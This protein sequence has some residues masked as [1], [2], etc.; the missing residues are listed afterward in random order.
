MSGSLG[1]YLHNAGQVITGLLGANVPASVVWEAV[2]PVYDP[3]SNSLWQFLEGVLAVT[4]QAITTALVAE[5]LNPIMDEY[6]MMSIYLL[7]APYF[8]P[9]A[10]AKLRRWS[11]AIRDEIN[12]YVRPPKIRIQVPMASDPTDLPLRPDDTNPGLQPLPPPAV[13]SVPW[14]GGGGG[15]IYIDPNSGVIP[16][17]DPM[18]PPAN[19]DDCPWQRGPDGVCTAPTVEISIDD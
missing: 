9:N 10:L 4:G 6:T 18:N 15:D 5:T 16:N 12:L 13:D 8:M 17:F 14:G 19:L 1:W 7:Y 11:R 3:E 2:F